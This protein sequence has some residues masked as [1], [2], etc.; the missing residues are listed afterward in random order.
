MDSLAEDDFVD[1]FSPGDPPEVS[2]QPPV[3]DFVDDGAVQ[4]PAPVTNDADPKGKDASSKRS[5]EREVE[6]MKVVDRPIRTKPVKDT[7]VPRRQPMR[8][9]D[10]V[11][12]PS[13][14]ASAERPPRPPQMRPST[15]IHRDTKDAP[16]QGASIMTYNPA[17]PAR[18]R[19][20]LTIEAMRRLGIIVSDI[21]YPSEATLNL[22]SHDP[23]FRS[24]ARKELCA[25]VDELVEQ[26]KEKR[27]ELR[28]QAEEER[29]ERKEKKRTRSPK[30]A[31]EFLAA[32]QRRIDRMAEEQRRDMENMLIGALLHGEENKAEEERQKKQAQL[33]K[34]REAAADKRRKDEMEAKLRRQ[35]EL[36][37]YEEERRKKEDQERIRME[38]DMKRR[39]KRVEE[40]RSKKKKNA[41][42]EEKKRLDKI[43]NAARKIALMQEEKKKE[44]ERKDQEA[45]K[46]E[47]ARQ[48]KLKEEQKRLAS[49]REQRQAYMEDLLQRTRL[50]QLEQIE[51][52]R[53]EA[54]EKDKRSEVVLKRCE[55]SLASKLKDMAEREQKKAKIA[56]EVRQKKAEEWQENAKSIQDREKRAV[57]RIQEMEKQKKEQYDESRRSYDEGVARRQDEMKK[58][59]ELQH[60]KSRE[61]VKQQDERLVEIQKQRDLQERKRAKQAMMD[62]LIREKRKSAAFRA[63]RQREAEK[64]DVKVKYDAHIRRIE[65]NAQSREQA[66]AIVA[67]QKKKLGLQREEL[68]RQMEAFRMKKGDD[69]LYVKQIAANFGINFDDLKKKIEERKAGKSPSTL[70]ALQPDCNASQQPTQRNSTKNEKRE[71]ENKRESLDTQK[72]RTQGARKAMVH[73]DPRFKHKE[74]GEKNQ[75]RAK[76][77][78]VENNARPHNSENNKG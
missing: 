74:G 11:R 28:R 4:E 76:R 49:I 54:E 14:A 27:E 52:R 69:E 39:Q 40:E 24:M 77:E 17:L 30:E 71:C 32:E 1:D 26:V 44:Y 67:I 59:L 47:V 65:E 48:K 45:Q 19:D 34:E 15:V 7:V 53:K 25:Q 5:S 2:D 50:A 56:V 51:K 70:P 8:K 68:I 62:R 10:P 38:E 9:S 37:R 60:E 55:E 31:N 46:R 66:R 63:E 61:L 78:S 43:E 35:Q 13:T 6:G 22:Y 57:V 73:E 20:P 16:E 33:A 41:A 36:E 23:E 58:Q 12:R 21:Q 29:N 3:D 42:E 72:E 64:Q 75:T 18:F